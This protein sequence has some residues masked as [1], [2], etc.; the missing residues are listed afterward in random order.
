MLQA[1]NSTYLFHHQGVGLGFR[2]LNAHSE[3]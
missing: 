3:Q 2:L 1:I